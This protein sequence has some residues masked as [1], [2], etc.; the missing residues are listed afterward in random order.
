MSNSMVISTLVQPTNHR[1]LQSVDLGSHR[2][3]P[4]HLILPPHPGLQAFL[5]LNVTGIGGRVSTP[6]RC[7]GLDAA[8][9]IRTAPEKFSTH[10]S[11]AIVLCNSGSNGIRSSK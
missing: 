11:T 5:I 1:P 10:V 7:L 8:S 2:E 3:V 4:R 9:A 6:G